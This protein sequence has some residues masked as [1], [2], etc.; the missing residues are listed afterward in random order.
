MKFIRIILLIGISGIFTPVQAETLKQILIRLDNELKTKDIYDSYKQSRIDSMCLQLPTQHDNPKALCMEYCKIAREYETFISDS[1]LAYYD[2]AT[3]LAKELNDTTPAIQARLGRIKVMSIMGFFH[4]AMTELDSIEQNGIPVILKEQW[5]D[6]G[7]QLYSYIEAYTIQGNSQNMNPYLDM[8]IA[9]QNRYRTKLLKLLP[10][11]SPHHKLYLAEQ[12]YIDGNYKQAKIL[13]NE[14]INN[15]NPDNNIYARAAANMAAIREYEDNIDDATRF[16]ALSAIADIKT[17]VK[18]T[19]SLQKLAL[20]L[21]ETGDI[22]HAYAYLSASLAD[23]VFCN[24]RLRTA[25]ISSITPLIDG[26]YK[27]QLNRKHKLLMFATLIST[28]LAIAFVGVCFFLL[29]Q[30][31][32]LND[33]RRQLKQANNI[34]EEYIGHFLDLCSIYM[35]RLDNFCKTV[36]RKITAGQIEELV[37]MAKSSKFAEEQH[38]QFYENFDGAFLHI[39]PTFID[40]FNKLLQPDEQIIIKDPGRLTTEL[41]IFAFF[42]MGVDDANK[43]AGFLHYSVNT[44]YAYRNKVKNKAIDREHFEENIMKI[45]SIQ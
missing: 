30:M 9:N 34:K 8:Y 45:G 41:R 31:R 22:G 16:L 33:T 15:S 14:I 38:K 19:T 10:E 28:L 43:I 3:I 40:D 29:K 25:E 24:A 4:E 13:L 36:T 39:Y 32:K 17:S 7:R 44:I 21:Y 6:C 20:H 5:L 23:A 18:E 42:R 2:R 11:N 26:A 12:Y 37:K 35:D 27:V 1:A